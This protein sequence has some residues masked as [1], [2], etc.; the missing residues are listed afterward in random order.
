[1]IIFSRA[2]ILTELRFTDKS[3]DNFVSDIHIACTIAKKGG[4]IRE[5]G[6]TLRLHFT[7]AQFFASHSHSHRMRPLMTEFY[8]KEREG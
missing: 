1:M 5:L 7:R 2:S 4:L 8:T 3:V 6:L